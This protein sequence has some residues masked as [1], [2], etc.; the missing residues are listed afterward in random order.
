M[1]KTVVNIGYHCLRNFWSAF[2]TNQSICITV[3]ITKHCT[4]VYINLWRHLPFSY[5]NVNVS[6]CIHVLLH[7]LFSLNVPTNKLFLKTNPFKSFGYFIRERMPRI[8][9]DWVSVVTIWARGNVATRVLKLIQQN[10]TTLAWRHLNALL[11]F[12]TFV[13]P[14]LTNNL[15]EKEINGCRNKDR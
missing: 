14:I 7:V 3:V 12:I 10:S 9:Y 15:H 5:V 11:H 6:R 13:T 8:K 4:F 1:N 2:K